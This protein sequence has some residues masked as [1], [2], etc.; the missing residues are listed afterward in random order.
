MESTLKAM[1]VKD[2]AVFGSWVVRRNKRSEWVF[3]ELGGDWLN[4][5]DA[6]YIAGKMA[7][8]GVAA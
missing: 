4:Y 7:A 3:G 8:K 6:A 1:K 2:S 5:G